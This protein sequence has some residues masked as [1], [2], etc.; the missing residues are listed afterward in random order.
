MLNSFG[1]KIMTVCRRL[2]DFMDPTE[3]QKWHVITAKLL[4]EASDGL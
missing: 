2:H 3:T 4:Y 1:V